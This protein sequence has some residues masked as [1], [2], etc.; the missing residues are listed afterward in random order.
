MKRFKQDSAYRYKRRA[1]R[2]L[3]HRSYHDRVLR[4]ESELLSTAAYIW[5]NP[6]KAGLAAAPEAY[7]F[8]GSVQL[9][10]EDRPEGLSVRG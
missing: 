1:G 7:P 3:W 9:L 8:S 5:N 4:D 6:V 10:A 2:Q